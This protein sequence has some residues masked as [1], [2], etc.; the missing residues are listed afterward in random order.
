MTKQR[1]IPELNVRMTLLDIYELKPHV[2]KILRSLP[3]ERRQRAMRYH[4]E[5]DR[6]RSIGSSLLIMQTIG[7]QKLQYNEY[8]KPFVLGKRFNVSHSGNYVAL[9]EA[10]NPVGID[11]EEIVSDSEYQY[12]LA[13]VSLTQREKLWVR[14]SSLRFLILWTRK[15]SL[16]KCV[17]TG[18]FTEPNKVDVLA[19][20]LTEPVLFKGKFYRLFT[21]IFD[22]HL[23]SIA[24]V[25]C[26]P[27]GEQQ[28]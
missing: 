7:N 14:G 24:N 3:E 17:G 12:K 2:E 13:N 11:I 26:N 5:D 8:G 9:A 16:L 21:T 27:C 18:F 22:N 10:P 28:K 4:K 6:L 1:F 23:I 20:D 15:E 25:R 19:N